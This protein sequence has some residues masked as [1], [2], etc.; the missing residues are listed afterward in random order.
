MHRK[1]SVKYIHTI[2][3]LYKGLFAPVEELSVIGVA[4]ALLLGP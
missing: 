2:L 3:E 4:A 1:Y